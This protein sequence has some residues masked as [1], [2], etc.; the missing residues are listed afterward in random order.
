LGGPGAAPGSSG[1]GG[2]GDL[3]QAPDPGSGGLGSGLGKD[4]STGGISA[5]PGSSSGAPAKITPVSGGDGPSQGASGQGDGSDDLQV[6]VAGEMKRFDAQMSDTKGDFGQFGGFA[7]PVGI[8]NPGP[9]QPGGAAPGST[10]APADP[11]GGAGG[12][13]LAGA[14]ST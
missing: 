12:Q 11:S 13:A 14:A 10:P 4:H 5:T 7:H 3:G 8:E 2:L 1:S 9:A 6:I